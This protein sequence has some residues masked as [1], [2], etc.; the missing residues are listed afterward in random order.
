MVLKGVHSPDLCSG[1]GWFVSVIV[2]VYL[3]LELTTGWSPLHL[4]GFLILFCFKHFVVYMFKRCR[5]TT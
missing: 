5:I 1:I 3:A 4:S 2:V